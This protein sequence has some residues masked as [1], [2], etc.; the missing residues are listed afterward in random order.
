MTSAKIP[1]SD[2][3]ASL[4]AIVLAAG[5][6][7]RMGEFKPL[8]PVDGVPALGRVIGT[9]REAGVTDIH[10]VLGHR[11]DELRPLVEQS[12]A[13]A[14]LNKKFPQGMFTSVQAAV[15]ALPESCQAAFV[16]PADI[17]LVRPST[18]RRLAHALLANGHAVIYPVFEHR[19]GHPPLIPQRILR[20][21]LEES[22]EST[23]SAM[24]AMYA[25]ESCELFIPDE[26]ILLDMDTPEER[27]EVQELAEARGPNGGRPI[28]SGREC[29]AILEVYQ[30]RQDVQAHSRAVARIAVIIGDELV[31]R[32][33]PL[34]PRLVL[35]GALL[36]DVAKGESNHALAGGA[37]LRWFGFEPAAE[38]VEAH[39]DY[40]PG[41][42]MIDEAAVVHVADKL[43]LSDRLASLDE[44]F[45]R[46]E[47]RFTG[48]PEAREA[49][50]RRRNQAEQIACK[51]AKVLG[52]ELHSFCRTMFSSAAMKDDSADFQQA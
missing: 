22:M 21:T 30:P 10:V 33:V 3:F 2:E 31:L 39:Q 38:V 16:I 35:S 42:S 11:A 34:N 32:G 8:L 45:T 43:V 23:L 51:M 14:V 7:S 4:S 27:A 12:G 1:R 41:G 37:L 17:P 52:C 13:H 5:Y 47:Q 49:I 24:L 19:R 18:I 46:I 44:R 9:F 15:A 36:H 6:S 50:R 25:Q 20:Q 40:P 29:E 48:S 28:P 26:A